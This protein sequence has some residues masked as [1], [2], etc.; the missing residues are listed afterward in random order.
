MRRY[1]LLALIIALIAVVGAMYS[2]AGSRPTASPGQPPAAQGQSAASG[3]KVIAY[4]FVEPL[5]EGCK[6]PRHFTPLRPDLSKN[7]AL[8]QLRVPTAGSWC[9][10][11]LTAVSVDTVNVVASAE[12]ANTNEA[13][14][15]R[16]T[17]FPSVRWVRGAPD[18]LGRQVELRTIRYLARASG[19][20]AEPNQNVH[21][22]FVVVK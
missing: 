3:P 4:G 21:F 14:D 10:K 9:F 16:I 7:V 1:L 6:S 8:G 11:L 19:L 5:C 15:Q 2:A 13:R 18:C 20:V 22:S 12:G 17:T